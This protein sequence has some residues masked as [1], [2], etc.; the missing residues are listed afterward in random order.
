MLELAYLSNVLQLLR[1][2]SHNLEEMLLESRR[3][4]EGL[5]DPAIPPRLQMRRHSPN[6]SSSR[7]SQQFPPARFRLTT[8]QRSGLALSDEREQRRT[9]PSSDPL[10]FNGF[11][12]DV[13]RMFPFNWFANIWWINWVN[14]YWLTIIYLQLDM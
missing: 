9:R 6:L 8:E 1:Q 12:D 4:Y 14:K 7:F 11:M 5:G 2:R 3:M 10:D 13:Y